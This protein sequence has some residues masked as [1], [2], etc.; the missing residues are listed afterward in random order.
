MYLNVIHEGST[1]EYMPLK[2][3]ILTNS[4]LAVYVRTDIDDI[5]DQDFSAIV[6]DGLSQITV[7]RGVVSVRRL[8]ALDYPVR[9][10]ATYKPGEK[11]YFGNP[12]STYDTASLFKRIE[13]D[14]VHWTPLPSYIGSLGELTAET[15]LDI[16][17]KKRLGTTQ[18]HGWKENDN[19]LSV[20]T[21]DPVELHSNCFEMCTNM[22]SFVAHRTIEN[23][24]QRGF[25]GNGCLST[26]IIPGL[27]YIG[28]SAFSY[29]TELTEIDLPDTLLS[30]GADAFY[31]SGI[32]SVTIR[33]LRPPT[34]AMPRDIGSATLQHIYV[35]ASAVD[36]YKQH[37]QWSSL[38]SKIEAI[39][40]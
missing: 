30:I 32:V 34:L 17:K 13:K 38:A 18:L 1:D 36:T 31:S 28:Q 21:Y 29:C 26:V 22:R 23:V 8:D 16:F 3:L 35:P 9:Y 10:A 37:Q 25:R 7:E 6:E 14:G 24:P 2:C 15:R 5:I 27:K 12:Q 19:L 20:E 40:E 4:R 39:P 11:V 33:A